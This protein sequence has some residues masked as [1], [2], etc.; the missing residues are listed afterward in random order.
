MIPISDTFKTELTRQ[1]VTPVIVAIFKFPEGDYAISDRVFE[2]SSGLFTDDVVISWGNYVKTSSIDNA[3]LGTGLHTPSMSM[4]VANTGP[5]YFV[6]RLIGGDPLAVVVE[7][8]NYLSGID[9]VELIGK[10]TIQDNLSASQ[11]NL[12]INLD[13]VDLTLLND[14]YIGT[15]DTVNHNYA[16]VPIGAVTGVPGVPFGVNPYAQ[17]SADLTPG[18]TI[19]Y[20]DRDL[21]TVGFPVSGTVEIGFDLISYTGISGD[22]FTGCTGVEE[23]AS[24]GQFITLQGH[25]YVFSFGAG[26]VPVAGPVYINNVIYDGDYIIDKDNDPVTVTFPGRLPHIDTVVDPVYQHHTYNYYKDYVGFDN[27]PSSSDLNILVSAHLENHWTGSKWDKQLISDDDYEYPTVIARQTYPD[28]NIPPDAINVRGIIKVRTTPTDRMQ[29]VLGNSSRNFIQSFAKTTYQGSITNHTHGDGNYVEFQAW[30]TDSGTTVC[31]LDYFSV[32][33]SWD[34]LTSAGST[35]RESFDDPTLNI[36][37][38]TTSDANP[39]DVMLSIISK[40]PKLLADNDS[41]TIAKTWYNDNGYYFNGFIPGEN[42]VIETLISMLEQ[43]R[44]YIISNAGKLYLYILGINT[45]IPPENIFASEGEDSVVEFSINTSWQRFEDIINQYNVVYA[46]DATGA[47]TGSLIIKNQ[48]SINT[49]GKLETTLELPLVTSALMASDVSDYY[50][51]DRLKPGTF[52]SFTTLLE[53]FPIE[54]GDY[55]AISTEYNKIGYFPGRVINFE[56][57]FASSQSD[58]LDLITLTLIGYPNGPV[59]NAE[60][61]YGNSPFGSLPYGI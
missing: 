17:L 49:Y 22:N 39:A 42:R 48:E 30:N 9:D 58:T 61:G 50:L 28:I 51:N 20:T 56:R 7:I 6:S 53:A 3:A 24:I 29:Y 1:G 4:T 2:Y 16:G 60:Y 44:S 38:D 32:T 57:S 43:T 45:D 54:I 34:T 19:V 40:N 27:Y 47:F 25:D 12:S 15:L 52:A 55:A 36:G 18:D 59:E 33:A 13:L 11:G 37:D 10:F 14:P 41:F 21:L 46:E 5:D 35:S 31:F 23:S 26:P 8:W